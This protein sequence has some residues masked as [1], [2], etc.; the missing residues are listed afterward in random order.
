M[1][2]LPKITRIEP[3]ARR[4]QDEPTVITKATVLNKR[5]HEYRPNKVK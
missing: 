4:A 5:D 3:E 2:L 1:D